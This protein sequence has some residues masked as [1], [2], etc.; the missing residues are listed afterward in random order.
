MTRLVKAVQAAIEWIDDIADGGDL[1]PA[2]EIR[3]ELAAALAEQGWRSMDD[4][5]NDDRPVWVWRAGTE[6]QCMKANGA[7][8]RLLRDI[9]P[10]KD[11]WT[12]WHP[13]LP[14]PPPESAR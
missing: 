14:P 8:W 9:N 13:C 7:F 6:P 2:L 1:S 3:D 5:P 12:H 4:C 10:S 11:K